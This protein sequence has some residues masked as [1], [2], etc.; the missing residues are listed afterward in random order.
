M[1]G[2]WIECGLNVKYLEYSVNDYNNRP[3]SV[4]KLSPNDVVNGNSFDVE[5]YKML[6]QKAKTKRIYSNLNCGLCNLGSK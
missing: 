3:H 6:I 2:L 4:L 5:N 1:D